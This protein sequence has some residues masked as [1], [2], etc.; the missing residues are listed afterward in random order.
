MLID[1]KR[2]KEIKL[3]TAYP[4]ETLPAGACL[5]NNY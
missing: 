3:G 1:T 5:V 4:F 2:E